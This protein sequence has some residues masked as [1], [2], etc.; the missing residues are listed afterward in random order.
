[1][2][3]GTAVKYRRIELK[4]AQALIFPHRFFP[5]S[6]IFG[7]GSIVCH[8]HSDDAWPTGDFFAVKHATHFGTLAF[9][10]SF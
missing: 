9:H 1:L 7:A 8:C 2:W 4:G 5:Q 3:R 6:I 10:D